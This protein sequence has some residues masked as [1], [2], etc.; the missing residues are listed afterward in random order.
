MDKD[1]ET[2]K[3]R[4]MGSSGQVMTA[5]T[6]IRTCTGE[7]IGILVE[8]IRN[9]FRDVAER[10]GLTEGNAPRH[11]S[12]CTAEWIRR[13]ME[14]GVTYFIVEANASAAG[15][16]ALERA[17]GDV[18]YLERLAVLPRWRHRGLGKRLVDHVLSEARCVGAR[19]VSIGIIAEQVE[20][21]NWY[22]RQGFVE[23]AVKDFS[24]LP[25]RVA[26]MNCPI[27]GT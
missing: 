14:R 12:N 15:C 3:K 24:H 25:F 23:T 9:S 10:Y 2:G 11:P 21:K 22:S 1:E 6:A 27:D 26:F 4:S 20:L 16:A 8:T 13:D 7:D 18:C 5:G 17:D 19:F